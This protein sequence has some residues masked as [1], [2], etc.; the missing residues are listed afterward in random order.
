MALAASSDRGMNRSLK[1]FTDVFR[2]IALFKHGR[3]IFHNVVT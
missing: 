1:G 2:L 3:R